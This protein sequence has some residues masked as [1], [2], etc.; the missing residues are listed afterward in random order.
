MNTVTR[1][2]PVPSLLLAAC[3]AVALVAP[4]SAASAADRGSAEANFR[5]EHQQCLSGHT[6]QDRA[7]CLREARNAYAD[8]R[9]GRLDNGESP[10]QLI[11]NAVARCQ[12]QPVAER[13]QCERMARGEGTVVGSV[14]QGGMLRELVTVEPAPVT[15][16]Q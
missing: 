12:V 2:L 8:A 7:T 14:E 3:T 1:R 13:A 16:T 6:H 11:A 4:L 15:R 9:R 10:Q 5:Y